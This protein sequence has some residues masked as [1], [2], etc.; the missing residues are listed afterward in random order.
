MAAYIVRRLLQTVVVIFGVTL[1]S[2]G[3]VFATGDP[4]LLLVGQNATAEQIDQLRHQMGFDRPWLVQ[5]L[6]YMSRAVRGDFGTSLRSREPAFNLV[7]DRMPATLE[8][9]GAALLFSLAVA[10][11]VGIISAVRRD[12][13][14]DH[15]SMLGALLGQSVPAFW[16]GLML[17]LILGVRLR[18]FPISGAGDFH[19]LILPAV[20]LGTYSLARN[21]R[22]IRSS[23]LEVLGLD[24]VRTARAKGLPPALVLRRHVLK[25]AMLPVVTI[26]GLDLGVLLGGAVITETIFAWPGVGRLVVSAIQGKD[27]PLIQAAV[28]LLAV[29][30]VV[31]NLVVDLAYTYFDPRIR[32][33]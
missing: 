12:S 9:T 4:T 29:F 30:F 17:I 2:F 7:I 16:L 20:T 27:Y 8:L 15:L 23:M 25:N 26:V 22:L 28:T 5:Y 19:H 14:Y 13:V 6:D 10:F 18:W 24:F 3:V 32:L 31:L 21:A 33:S 1:L 11:P